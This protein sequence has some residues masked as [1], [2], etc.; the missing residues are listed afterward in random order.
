MFKFRKNYAFIELDLNQEIFFRLPP[1]SEGPITINVTHSEIPLPSRPVIRASRRPR[2]WENITVHNSG[3]VILID[4]GGG[5]GGGGDGGPARD[6]NL[7]LKHS[8]HLSISHSNSILA[9]S[10]WY[11]DLW[12]LRVRRG[13]D[14]I[15]PSTD[16]R[17]YRIEAT[18]ISQLPILERRIPLTFFQNGLEANWNKNQYV[19]AYI[20]GTEVHIEFRNDFA[21]LYGQGSIKIP[22]DSIPSWAASFRNVVTKGV[23]LGVGA[24]PA[25]TGGGTSVFLSVRVDFHEG[26]D[27]DYFGP[28]TIHFPAFYII[29]RLYLDK[30]GP[31]LKYVPTVESDHFFEYIDEVPFIDPGDDA[32]ALLVRKLTEAQFPNGSSNSKFG[33]FLTPWLVGGDFELESLG[34]APSPGDASGPSGIIEPAT[35]ELIVSYVGPRARPSTDGNPIHTTGEPSTGTID[36]G[37][38]RL[39]DVPFEEY[40]PPSA[41]LGDPGDH[42]HANIGWLAKINHIVV[43]MQ[44]NRSFDQVLGYLSRD[45]INNRVINDKVSGLLPDDHPGHLAQVNFLHN[46]EF[47]PK[48]AEISE[49]AR[50]TVTAWPG[51]FLDGPHHGSN[52]VAEQI[53]GGSM[54]GFVSN[55]AKHI[56][57]NGT[58]YYLRLIMDYFGAEELPV[59]AELARQFGICDHWFASFAGGTLPNRYV[60]LTGRLNRDRFG[61]LEEHNPD[62][63]S[64]VPSE[65]PTLFDYLSKYG[66]S[67]RVYE[68]GY[69]FAR[70]FGKHTFDITNVVPFND[71]VQG[72]EAAARAGTLPD[73][74]WIEPDYIEL[75]PGNDDH[76]PAD[77]KD[78]QVLVDKIV[79]ALVASPKWYQTL[80]IITYDEHG[81]FYDHMT[82]PT[83]DPPLGDSRRTMGPRVPAFVISPLIKAGSVFDKQFDHTSIGATILRRF[84]RGRPPSVSARLDRAPDLREVLEL[85]DSPSLRT[86]FG[87]FGGSV[88]SPFISRERSTRDDHSAILTNSHEED[89]HWLLAVTRL[90]TG[91]AFKSGA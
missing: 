57:N 66:R 26:G 72:F 2:P 14:P 46:T 28:D 73:V 55:F 60:A 59:Y 23:R 22:L 70:L 52:D 56:G 84:C 78:G 45:K 29:A 31:F 74:T 3:T 69:S 5:G 4:G 27:L 51:Y 87:S 82:P 32:K 33:E 61:N 30:S 71:R 42:V 88:V 50:L 43:L 40:L 64:L 54:G 91:Q 36:D 21:L 81:G 58:P 85:A 13:P 10:N 12:R 80:L 19:W 47:R 20:D 25:P 67:W 15:S 34:Y 1:I 65:L 76:A 7:E 6:L 41:T 77:M 35:G 37:S 39:F 79:R 24:G 75:P 63:N 11:D 86:D 90:I 48:K 8:N 83:N 17:K 16:R 89:F 18:Y 38:I 68:H 53:D 44:E 9:I 62:P 49:P